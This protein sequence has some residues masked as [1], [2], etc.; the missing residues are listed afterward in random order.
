MITRQ[1]QYYAGMDPVGQQRMSQLHGG[2]RDRLHIGPNPVRRR[3]ADP[4]RLWDVAGRLASQHRRAARSLRGAGIDT[5]VLSG[6]PHLEEAFRAAELL[7]PA[8]P[9][10][11]KPDP[12]RL[13]ELCRSQRFADP[14]RPARAS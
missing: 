5:L 12:L 3:R 8:L 1:Q 10:W 9:S 14:V 7:F 2:R 4:R 6:Y 11:T 13:P